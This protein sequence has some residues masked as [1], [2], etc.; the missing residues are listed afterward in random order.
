M[1]LPITVKQFIIQFINIFVEGFI[2]L[3]NINTVLQFPSREILL[4]CYFLVIRK[5]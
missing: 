4:F 2:F 5:K 3:K 1:F